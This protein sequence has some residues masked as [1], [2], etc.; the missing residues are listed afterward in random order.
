VATAGSPSWDDA[1]RDAESAPQLRREGTRMVVWLGGEQDMYTAAAVAAALA[2]AD[3]EGEGDVVVDL[4]EVR[5]VGAAIVTVLIGGGNALRQR[6][7]SLV[8][9]DPPPFVRRILE[10]CGLAGLVEAG[11][12]VPAGGTPG[13]VRGDGP[14]PSRRALPLAEA[15]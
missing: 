3:A 5:F 1:V 7:R 2:R 9:R 14:A 12:S 6:S 11:P 10:V 13:A 8:L 15:G 4:S